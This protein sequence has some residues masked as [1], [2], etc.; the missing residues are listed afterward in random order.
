MTSANKTVETGEKGRGGSE[1]G[2]GVIQ[3]GERKGERQTKLMEE[4]FE[5]EGGN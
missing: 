1:G 5:R 4:E 2:N 3:R